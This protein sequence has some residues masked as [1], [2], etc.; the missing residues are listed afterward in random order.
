MPL[1]EK[2]PANDLY[3]LFSVYADTNETTPHLDEMQTII[4]A[5]PT[6][7]NEV[8][9]NGNSLFAELF[10]YIGENKQTVAADQLIIILNLIKLMISCDIKITSPVT[11]P[12]IL[13]IHSALTKLMQ[14]LDGNA[15]NTLIMALG[16]DESMTLFQYLI[17]FSSIGFSS[18]E[19][20]AAND[21]ALIL[22]RLLKP[23]LP[24]QEID[25]L[26]K[27]TSL[28]MV[29]YTDSLEIVDQFLE[30]AHHLEDNCA[31]G[32]VLSKANKKNESPIFA[33][34][35][36]SKIDIFER[37]IKALHEA[38]LT[39]EL[40]QASLLTVLT[41]PNHQRKTPLEMA[42]QSGKLRRAC[43][44]LDLICLENT[45]NPAQI[46]T[47]LSAKTST[48][49]NYLH[50]IALLGS[51]LLLKR[52]I[53]KLITCLGKQAAF[54][55]LRYQAQEK[56]NSGFMS[57]YFD[58]DKNHIVNKCI[59]LLWSME[60]HFDNELVC[61]LLKINVTGPSSRHNRY[62][63]VFKPLTTVTESKTELS[64]ISEAIK[65]Q[66]IKQ[67]TPKH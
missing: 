27:N 51:E 38:L 18:R 43:S 42:I 20:P 9:E 54:A 25:T 22:L 6:L 59:R 41:A 45:F 33:A 8:S 47:I 26:I 4:M 13:I 24:K 61:F 17:S 58:S 63:S 16:H 36:N 55:L 2:N 64:T 12:H 1:Y 40:L 48:E 49:G 21:I 44:M 34:L 46:Q 31:Y 39:G 35:S 52:Y 50:E 65:L 14:A 3:R 10:Q 56:N 37:Y 23:R 5:D 28:E 30:A 60:T 57:Y 19:K 32:E 15:M 29:L 53:E 67:I 7:L 62:Q 11:N 66:A